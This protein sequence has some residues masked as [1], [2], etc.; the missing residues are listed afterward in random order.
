MYICLIFLFHTSAKF[1]VNNETCIS[2][3]HRMKFPVTF[4][5]SIKISKSNLPSGFNRMI[6]M[7]M[8]M[9][10]QRKSSTHL[11]T[12]YECIVEPTWL[13]TKC[14]RVWHNKRFAF[15]TRRVIDSRVLSQNLAEIRKAIC[16]A[17]VRFVQLR[18]VQPGYQAFDH[19]V[20][21]CR[22][23]NERNL[24]VNV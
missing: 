11:G 13:C 5:E 9:I 6:M 16:W 20:E 21:H 12:L 4:H 10:H 17:R 2:L 19:V 15:F 8:G 7:S 23:W 3:S 1:K 24:H 18:V 22:I 14:H